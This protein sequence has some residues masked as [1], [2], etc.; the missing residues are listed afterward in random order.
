MAVTAQT[1]KFLYSGGSSNTDPAASHGGAPG[2]EIPNPTVARIF[3]NVSEAQ[4][5]AGH[6]DYRCIYVKNESAS[7][8][9]AVKAWIQANTPA[10]ATEV[11]MALDVHAI[12]SDAV[13]LADESVRPAGQSYLGE[14]A[15]PYAPAADNGIRGLA[16]VNSY[17]IGIESGGNYWRFDSD[18][19]NPTRVTTGSPFT[20][21]FARAICFASTPQK[22]I[23]FDKPSGEDVHARDI[24]WDDTN[25]VFSGNA[26]EL[27][28]LDLSASG[29]LF[30]AAYDDANSNLIVA[31]GND[32]NVFDYASNT[33]VVSGRVANANVTSGV[34][35]RI[36]GIALH[37]GA[38][39]LFST[40][41]RVY[42][43]R[44][45]AA[46]KVVDQRT[47]IDDG[48]LQ[49]QIW[50]AT[51]DDDHLYTV[52]RVPP[53]NHTRIRSFEVSESQNL[54]TF[55]LHP[56]SDPVTIGDMA[57]GAYKAIWLRRRVTATPVDGTYDDD[58]VRVDAR[59]E[60]AE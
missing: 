27:S 54:L 60:T 48:R 17:F 37:G 49:E 53:S 26:R 11:S 58:S 50:G 46:T 56:P 29:N 8:W 44:Y 57:A 38:L 3:D 55:G 22:V 2:G 6:V 25:G 47:E 13:L 40:T 45:T 34:S 15:E 32:I 19:G 10:P 23:V 9:N 18:F 31:V 59:G 51:A 4:L 41:G 7:A 36:E 14:M 12:N 42:R 28:G 5:R 35:G 39:W 24:D 30:A 52:G 1:V 33:G 20:L 16:K 21:S 43:C